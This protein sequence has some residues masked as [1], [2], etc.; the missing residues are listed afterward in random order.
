[1]AL[2]NAERELLMGVALADEERQFERFE[3]SMGL[4]WDVEDLVDLS[5]KNLKGDQGQTQE[6]IPSRIRIPALIALAPEMFK[7][8]ADGYR[9]KFAARSMEI[10]QNVPK[11]NTLVELSNLSP[12]DAKAFW[13]R[14][15]S[16]A[17]TTPAPEAD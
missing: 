16:Q 3:R 4:L 7:S 15:L 5:V 1:M 13:Q 10:A 2:S 14:I 6:A 9:K 12:T 11:G 8:V 17:P